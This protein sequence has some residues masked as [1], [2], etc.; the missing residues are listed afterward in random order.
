MTLPGSRISAT[1]LFKNK[2][3]ALNTLINSAEYTIKQEKVFFILCLKILLGQ[4]GHI[5]S[6]ALNVIITSNVVVY[7]LVI[8]SYSRW[9]LR[10]ENDFMHVE[11]SSVVDFI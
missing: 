11:S 9:L 4:S 8:H 2:L 10:V 7:A 3:K 1:Y 6:G 5:N